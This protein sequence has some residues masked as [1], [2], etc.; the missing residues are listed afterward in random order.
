MG[1]YKIFD[2]KGVVQASGQ[3]QAVANYLK[4]KPMPGGSTP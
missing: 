4:E 2:F 3:G 1:A